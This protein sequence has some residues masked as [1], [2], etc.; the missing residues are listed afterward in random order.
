MKKSV[1][2]LEDISN[3]CYGMVTYYK[4]NRSINKSE[5]YRDGRIDAANWINEL[6]YYYIQKE[7]NFLNEF[8]IYIEEQKDKISI[9]KDGDYKN[10]LYDQLEYVKSCIDGNIVKR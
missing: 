6:I 7:K 10:G 8:T 3:E 2:I 9:L 4:Y 1:N 5:K